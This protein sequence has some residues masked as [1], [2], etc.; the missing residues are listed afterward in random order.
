MRE[1][2]DVN[3]YYGA[4]EIFILKKN[5]AYRRLNYIDLKIII[6]P[7]FKIFKKIIKNLEIKDRFLNIIFEAVK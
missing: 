7:I 5:Q 2:I 6:I 4:I 3:I 1:K